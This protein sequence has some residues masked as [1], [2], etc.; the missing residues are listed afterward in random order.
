MKRGGLYLWLRSC[1]E[2]FLVSG[3]PG[4]RCVALLFGAVA[5]RQQILE[6]AA[7]ECYPATPRPAGHAARRLQEGW[8]ATGMPGC[9]REAALQ[10]AAGRMCDF[11]AISQ[12][13]S[14]RPGL[15]PGLVAPAPPPLPAPVSAAPAT[16]AAFATDD[17]MP[18]PCP[19]A[20]AAATPNPAPATAAGELPPGLTRPT[21]RPPPPPSPP[22]PPQ[23]QRVPSRKNK[24]RRAHA[25]SDAPSL[26]GSDAAQHSA[27]KLVARRPDFTASGSGVSFGV[28]SAEYVRAS[29]HTRA[30]MRT[31]AGAVARA[32]TD[33]P[34]GMT[35]TGVS[36]GT[37]LTPLTVGRVG[38]HGL[39]VIPTSSCANTV[40]S[41]SCVDHRRHARQWW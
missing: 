40:P 29:P 38:V 8:R 16:F 32:C 41:S 11:T 22:P 24:C 26:A 3:R 19:A 36:R 39:R 12:A 23:Q 35:N 1:P 28:W 25:T 33:E 14:P 37:V 20:I 6:L 34:T 10:C 9:G 5:R 18:Y 2:L 13:F 21:P 30:V 27:A 7:E 17:W 31:V 15:H 4:R